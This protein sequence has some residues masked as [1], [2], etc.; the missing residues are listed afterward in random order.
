M[1]SSN[2][3]ASRQST[4]L[5]FWVAGFGV[6][7][8]AP[9]VPFARQ[10]LQVD[11]GTLG[12]LFLCLGIGSVVAMLRTGPLCA[13]HGSKPV[14]LAGGAGMVLL[15]PLLAIVSTPWLLASTLLAFGA[16][17]GSLDVAMNVHAVEVERD[18]GRPMM[19]GF[20]A[21]FSVG[22]FSGSALV[23]VLLTLSIDPLPVTLICSAAM[24]VALMVTAPRLRVIAPERQVQTGALMALP[25][26]P[27]VLLSALTA[28]TFLVEGALLDWSALLLADTGLA[29]TE[30]AGLGYALF[31]VAMTVGRFSGDALTARFGDRAVVFWGGVAVLGGFMLLLSVRHVEPALAGFV[32]IGLGASNVV[33][34]LFRQAGAQSAMP[35]ALAISAVT[36][37]GYAGYLLGPAAVGFISKL[38]GLPAAFWMLAGLICL[39]PISARSATAA[40]AST[41]QV[42]HNEDRARRTLDT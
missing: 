32:L 12:L 33:P 17:L 18:A 3:L 28:V 14:I 6:S 41:Q 21:L 25:R 35:A 11:D 36:T 27:V 9:L 2:S 7:A 16:A 38:A 20:H 1:A 5:A 40:H 19:S 4:R 37:M 15:L 13:R 30:R 42:S 31:S 8:W 34:V 23:T 39:V 26:G 10:R 22:G 24:A 29:S